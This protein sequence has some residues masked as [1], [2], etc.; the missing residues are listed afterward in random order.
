VR[1]AELW[2]YP[3]KSLAGERLSTVNVNP[4]G[5]EGDRL[6]ALVDP[7][8]GIASGKTTRRFRALSGLMHHR[9]HLEH[10]NPVITSQT[11]APRA[12]AALRSPS[13][14]PRSRRLA[15]R[16]NAR[17]AKRTLTRGRST[18]SPPRR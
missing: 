6:W 5:V 12:S 10:G 4:R 16:C 2:R 3:I 8:G 7:E 9:S 14:S 11:G 17:T 18:S 15:G 1:L 13:S